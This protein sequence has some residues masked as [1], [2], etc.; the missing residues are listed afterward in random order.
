M[1]AAT[2]LIT[3]LR[4]RRIRGFTLIEVLVALII[5][6]FGMSAVF[7]AL[8][9]S[10]NSTMRLREKSFAEWVGFNQLATV[11]LNTS[12]PITGRSEGDATFAGTRWHCLQTVENMDIPGLLRVTI[13]VRYADAKRGSQVGSQ[14][15][16]ANNR[17]TNSN[18]T[19]NSDTS[20]SASSNSAN[21]ASATGRCI[22]PSA[23]TGSASGGSGAGDTWLATVVGFYGLGTLMTAPQGT[24]SWDTATSGNNPNPQPTTGGLP[25]PTPTPSPNPAGTG[26]P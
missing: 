2:S 23:N 1:I 6:A 14:S 16:T 20:D 17:S 3:V 10:A 19:G 26:T 15:V 24:L 5:V 9:S 8:T 22:D 21:S 25:T 7:V 18:T 12:A 13:Q 11:R 4:R